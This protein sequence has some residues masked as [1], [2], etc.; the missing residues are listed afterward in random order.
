MEDHPKK[1]DNFL[2]FRIRNIHVSS[3]THEEPF[4][5]LLTFFDSIKIYCR[6]GRF[7][8]FSIDKKLPQYKRIEK[9]IEHAADE[10]RQMSHNRVPTGTAH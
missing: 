10:P 8:A 2:L 6:S 7:A 3:G 9:R 1:Y 4:Y 5:Y